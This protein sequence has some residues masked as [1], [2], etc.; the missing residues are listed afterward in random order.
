MSVAARNM[1][2][3]FLWLAAA[4]LLVG[5]GT[6]TEQPTVNLAIP[7]PEATTS[8]SLHCGAVA[9]ERADDALMNGYGFQIEES[10]FQEAY[11]DCMAWRSPRTG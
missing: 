1:I 3:F 6:E 5:C 11:Q 2:R 7:P 8:D 9:R 4:G 10:V